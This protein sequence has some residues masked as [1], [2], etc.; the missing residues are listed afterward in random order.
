MMWE[1]NLRIDSGW[2][3]GQLVELAARGLLAQINDDSAAERMF[4]YQPQTPELDRAVA[5]LSHEY[6]ER[7]VSVISLIFSK[8][9]DKIRSFADAFR[10]R[11]ERSDG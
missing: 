9:M 2:A 8:P 10:I 3:E 5:G 11:K 4:Q 7:R 6:A 1:R